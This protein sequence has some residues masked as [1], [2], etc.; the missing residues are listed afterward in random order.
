MSSHLLVLQKANVFDD[1]SVASEQDH[2]DA[3]KKQI[4]LLTPLFVPTKWYGNT[5]KTF[6]KAFTLPNWEQNAQQ[7]INPG[8]QHHQ[9]GIAPAQI[10]HDEDGKAEAIGNEFCAVGEHEEA[11]QVGGVLGDCEKALQRNQLVACATQ[12]SA[13]VNWEIFAYL[14]FAYF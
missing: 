8:Q 14:I 2:N 3:E 10:G 13:S 9:L 5:I 11:D 4:E 6:G 12:L 1:E 7:T